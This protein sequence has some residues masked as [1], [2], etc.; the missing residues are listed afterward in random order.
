[1]VKAV[2]FDLDGTLIDSV[3]AHAMAWL[4]A[5]NHLGYE[6]VKYEVL[7]NMIGLP[8]YEII[9]R[10]FGNGALTKYRE[11]KK[12]KDEVYIKLLK[13]GYITIYPDVIPT[14]RTLRALGLKLGLAS[15]TP[16]KTL[17]IVLRRFRLNGL[18]DAVIPGD[19]VSKGKPH[20]E[21][22][23]KAF[24]ELNVLPTSG[25]V[26][27]DSPYDIKPA[28]EMGCIAIL[29]T[30]GARKEVKPPPDYV[31]NEVSELIELIPKLG[32]DPY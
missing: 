6:G 22:F 7:I 11:F 31:I 9:R 10:L 13:E 27:G 14:L 25:C 32:I 17:S 21:I 26:V 12:I 15:S 29:V 3:R 18:F 4:K 24:K 2:V 1:L 23:I 8:G 19:K 16:S 28:K 5:F 20:P 30:H